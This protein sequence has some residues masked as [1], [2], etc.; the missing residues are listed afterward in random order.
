MREETK[1][2]RKESQMDRNYE[3]PRQYDGYGGRGPE[4]GGNRGNRNPREDTYRQS[5]RPG[6][7]MND[8]QRDRPSEWKD[9][10][11]R[12]TERPYNR[13]RSRDRFEGNRD[14]GG[15]R[16]DYYP[17]PQNENRYGREG[18]R[19]PRHAESPNQK[20]GGN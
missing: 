10:G 11:G 15:D 19:G 3:N 6:D 4:S 8:R 9:G 16:R 5:D 17:H 14:R 12:M 7:R 20:T 2:A 13:D 1:E 18:G